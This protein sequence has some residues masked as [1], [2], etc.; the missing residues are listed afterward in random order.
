M[1]L[2]ISDVLGEPFLRRQVEIVQPEVIVSLGNFATQALLGDRTAISRQ[3]GRWHQAY[4]AALMPTFHPAYLLR[5]PSD[6][7]LVWEDIKLVMERLGIAP[8]ARGRGA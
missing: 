7:R 2:G 8:P 3:R 4:G 1:A 6:K 5:N